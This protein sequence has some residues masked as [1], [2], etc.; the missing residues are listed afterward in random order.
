M[1]AAWTVVHS[2]GGSD[3]RITPLGMLHD[4]VHASSGR[5]RAAALTVHPGQAVKLRAL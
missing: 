5:L 2:S 4:S 1:F 3:D